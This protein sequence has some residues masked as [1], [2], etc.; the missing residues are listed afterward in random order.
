MTPQLHRSW[1]R[2][3]IAAVGGV[4]AAGAVTCTSA[5]TATRWQTGELV[6][7]AKHM[8]ALQVAAQTTLYSDGLSALVTDPAPA[9][10]DPLA[11]AAT[12]C[13]EAGALPALILLAKADGLIDAH[14]KRKIT[15]KIAATRVALDQAERALNGDVPLQVA[16]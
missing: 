6:M 14:E 12:A 10:E 3:L 11:H 15:D 9:G 2:Q 13:Q 8:A 4:E 5:P 16:G 1:A 7:N